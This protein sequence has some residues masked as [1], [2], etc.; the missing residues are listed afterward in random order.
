MAPKNC[1]LILLCAPDNLRLGVYEQKKLAQTIEI[2]G[3]AS[4]QLS[5]VF[6][7]LLQNHR[8]ETLCYSNGPGSFMAI[9]LSF[10]FLKSLQM[11]LGFKMFSV[12]LFYF[13][14]NAPIKAVGKMAFVKK[15]DKIC[16]IFMEEVPKSTFVL[17]TNFCKEDFCQMVQPQYYLNHLG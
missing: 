5:V 3:K 1:D 4:E 9:K 2:R 13:N 12:S 14:K 17:P 15:Q 16:T 7:K 8:I 6:E 11:V 10:I